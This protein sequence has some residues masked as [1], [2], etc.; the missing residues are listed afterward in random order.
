MSAY[1][2][3]CELN[4]SED[5][6][7]IM[8][9][10]YWFHCIWP[11]IQ[12]HDCWITYG[13]SIFSA[14]RGLMLSSKKDCSNLY[15]P[16]QDTIFRSSPVLPFSHYSMEGWMGVSLYISSPSQTHDPPDLATRVLGLQELAVIPAGACNHDCSLCLPRVAVLTDTKRYLTVFFICI[17]LT[18]NCEHFLCNFYSPFACIL[19]RSRYTGPL[20]F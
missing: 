6:N 1:H 7:V 16:Q 15:Y 13:N 17:S 2:G 18:I 9:S 19:S 3:S 8:T 10:A 5:I 4:F 11:S 20:S 14:L 12:Q